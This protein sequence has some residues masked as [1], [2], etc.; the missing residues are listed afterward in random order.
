MN[1]SRGMVVYPPSIVVFVYMGPH[2]SYHALPY[3]GEQGRSTAAVLLCSKV[4]IS[5]YGARRSRSTAAVESLALIN[6]LDRLRTAAL[7]TQAKHVR[8]IDM[9]A[10][11][12][13]GRGHTGSVHVRVTI[14]LI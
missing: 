1:S 14:Y 13:G 4:L 5:V 8:V 7:F 2:C 3:T 12:G 10:A 11:N 9:S 6:D